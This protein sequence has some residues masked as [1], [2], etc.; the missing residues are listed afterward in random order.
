[1]AANRSEAFEI[2][3]QYEPNEARR[4]LTMRKGVYPYEYIDSWARFKE[5]TQLPPKEAFYSKLSDENINEAD[6]AHARQ[7]WTTFGCKTLGNY[8]DLYCRTDFL[9]LADVFETFRRTCQKQYGLDPAHYY[10]SPGLSW[11][12][13]LKKTG[14]F[15]TFRRTCQKQYGLNPAHYYTSPGLSS[16]ALLNKTGVGL[17]LL[18]DYD[19]HLFIEKGMRGGHLNGL[20][21]PCQSQQ[22]S[23][24]GLRPRKA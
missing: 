18:T 17:E 6:Y 8:S 16:N 12:V 7:V 22:S 15:E 5:E 24:R 20:K 13:L 2:T 14:V 19:Q 10:T 11:D 3:A 1:M 9:L 4:K 21:A 23:G